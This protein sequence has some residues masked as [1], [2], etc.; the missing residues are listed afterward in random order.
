M[1]GRVVS[2]LN[3]DKSSSVGGKSLDH[4]FDPKL[5]QRG[6]PKMVWEQITKIMGLK[7]SSFNS[8]SKVLAVTFISFFDQILRLVGQDLMSSKTYS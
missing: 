2:R 3:G 1:P 6:C 4:C 7:L 5:C 8:L